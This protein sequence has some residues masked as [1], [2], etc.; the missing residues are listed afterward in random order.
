MGLR[1][2]KSEKA[3][4]AS[5]IGLEEVNFSV[6]LRGEKREAPAAHTP[7]ATPLHGPD[8]LEQDPTTTSRV[9]ATPF[10][11]VYEG[12][13]GCVFPSSSSSSLCERYGM[14]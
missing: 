3:I 8:N 12:V 11:R 13:H 10:L 14:N 4:G 2:E 1:G 7:P 6:G 5:K 9:S